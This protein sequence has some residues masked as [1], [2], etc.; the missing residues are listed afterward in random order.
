MVILH[1][2]R[3]V[4]LFICNPFFFFF[5]F[6]P[7]SRCFSVP[8]H[9][10]YFCNPRFVQKPPRCYNSVS[11]SPHQRPLLLQTR[12]E[13]RRVQCVE[14][15]VMRVPPPQHVSPA[16]LMLTSLPFLE[17]SHQ[18]RYRFLQG[19]SHIYIDH[20]R[21]R[22]EPTSRT[23]SSIAP[24]NIEE[25]P[26]PR[27]APHADRDDGRESDNLSNP[28]KGPHTSTSRAGSWLE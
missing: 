9:T 19:F 16:W 28:Y 14:G 26:A 13:Y 17:V 15:F 4:C 25:P 22:R 7:L 1:I 2:T 3:R 18:E 23:Q 24:S 21:A 6:L 27:H 10:P 12:L 5:A 11:S 8:H 20:E